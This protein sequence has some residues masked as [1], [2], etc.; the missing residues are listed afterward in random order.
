MHTCSDTKKITQPTLQCHS[1]CNAAEI[2]S[3]N[4]TQQTN[5]TITKWLS[6]PISTDVLVLQL[7]FLGETGKVAHWKT[8]EMIY[9]LSLLAGYFGLDS[10][11]GNLEVFLFFIHD[12]E[13]LFIPTCTLFWTSQAKRKRY[14]FNNIYS[15]GWLGV[16]WML[17]LSFVFNVLGDVHIL[18][19][20]GANADHCWQRGEGVKPKADHCWREG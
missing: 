5:A 7:H 3:P 18:C 4:F 13:E 1:N 15:F 9:R 12:K 14:S 11:L 20:P 16:W 8:K 2:S 10:W 17:F 6:I 19:Q